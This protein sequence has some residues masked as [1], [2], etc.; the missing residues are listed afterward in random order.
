MKTG[1]I[2]LYSDRGGKSK[3]MPDNHRLMIY[4]DQSIFLW[5]K[6]GLVVVAYN[7]N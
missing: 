4:K 5:H 3:F 7:W 6:G 2:N 1:K